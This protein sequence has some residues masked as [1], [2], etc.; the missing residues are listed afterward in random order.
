M[1]R[2]FFL[3]AVVLLFAET[4][5]A[6]AQNTKPRIA[7][8]N[9]NVA[10][11]IP[12][13][14]GAAAKIG[15]TLRLSFFGYNSTEIT[16]VDKL[17]PA[18]FDIIVI[19]KS[20]AQLNDWFRKYANVLKT[21]KL[22]VNEVTS[23]DGNLK[24]KDYPEF[25]DY[26]KNGGSDNAQRLFQFIGK[27]FFDLPFTIRPSVERPKMAFYHPDAPCLFY[28]LASYEKWYG[29]HKPSPTTHRYNPDSLSIGIVFSSFSYIEKNI[30][31]VDS[32]IRAIEHK[33][34]N[35][36][37]LMRSGNGDVDTLLMANGITQVDAVIMVLG[38]FRF[39]DYEKGI[40][41][42][43]KIN[44]PLLSAMNH[45]DYSPEQWEKSIDGLTLSMG[46]T[47]T[48]MFKD[49]VFEPMVISGGVKN[50]DGKRIYVPIMYQLNWRV[51][52]A[53]AWAR[54]HKMNNAGKRM[55][56]TFYSEDGGKANV[57][58]HPAN[59][60]NAPASIIKLL[61][62]MKAR[63]W[64]VGEKPLP[65]AKKL[66]R[67]LSQETSN[68]GNWAQGEI[69]RRVR[70]GNV[71]MIPES[72]YRQWFA[73]LPLDKQQQLVDSWGPPPGNVM[74]HTNAAGQKFIIIPKL[75][76]GNVL[77]A[78]NPD[79]GYLQNSKMLYSNTK[80][81]PSHQYFAFYCWFQKIYQPHVRFSIFNNL[82]VMEHKYIGPSKKDWLGMMTG[83]YPN[84][85]I[86][87]LMSG[88][89][90]KEIM[91]DL[92]VTYFNTIVPSG[93]N[94]NLTELRLKIKQLSDQVVPELKVELEKGIV[95]ETKRLKL[96]EQ[97]HLN[98]DTIQLQALLTQLKNYFYEIDLGNMPSGTHTLGEVPEGETR[99]AMIRAML[100][101]EF[102][103]LVQQAAPQ[104]ASAKNINAVLTD[105]LLKQKNSAQSQQKYLGIA[106]DTLSQQLQLALEY[107]RRIVASKNEI[108]QYLNA[109]EGKYIAPSSTD[110]PIRN[111]NAIPTGRNPYSF[112]AATAPTQEAWVMA[113]RL[114]DTLIAKY[115][116]KNKSYPRKIGFVLW[117]SEI[118]KNHGVLEAEILY[119][120]GAKPVWDSKSNVVG[121]EL[122]PKEVLKRPRIDVVATT[123]GDYRDVFRDKA[124]LI[125]EAV[126]L[127]AAA[128]EDS[129]IVRQHTQQYIA[130]LTK[131]GKSDAE[132]KRLSTIRVFSPAV[133][134]Y[135][136]SL[137]NVTKANDTWQSDTALSNLYISRMGH[138]YGKET[139][140]DYERDYFIS[141][142]QSV[143]AG[144][145]SRSSNMYGLL[146]AT[147]EPVAFFG[148]L[149]M[150][151][152]NSTGGRN[153]EMYMN[154][155]RDAKGS[156]LETLDDFYNKELQSRAF[157]PKWIEAMM[158]DDNSGAQYMQNITENLW[159]F[160]VTSPNIVQDKDW[161]ELNDVFVKDKF[162]LGLDEFFEKANP[163]AKQNILST[164][165]G[166]AEKGYWKADKEVLANLSKALAQSV[167]KNGAGCSSVICN[168]TTVQKFAIANLQAIPGG[169]DLAQGYL[170]GIATQTT[171]VPSLA[172]S[173]EAPLVIPSIVKASL[174]KALTKSFVKTKA[175]SPTVNNAP[176]DNMIKG[177]E[178][179]ETI[180]KKEE[181]QVMQN[182]QPLKK[183]GY[184]WFALLAF[185]AIG[186]V[187]QG[188]TRNEFI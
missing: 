9:A 88:E 95:A 41:Q 60:F 82:E 126:K 70:N 72:Q 116:D 73:E 35:A 37:A 113:Q 106:K 8:V 22:Y 46:S 77:L 2:L 186:W 80:L 26:I 140:G 39:V 123:S 171:A 132:A 57:G 1:K 181:K 165:L 36:F 156:K 117:A 23:Y 159:A 143:D 98:A 111:P 97:L 54:L 33:G 96:D 40:A 44:V 29:S 76:F 13:L 119:L 103:S 146:D 187:I 12:E 128:D 149:Q 102:E 160:N 79:W 59:Y 92:P 17:N 136:T 138:A 129:N 84:I 105:V 38:S 184:V 124:E 175:S 90:G 101:L 83:D 30:V 158:K 141:N 61:D 131:A 174:I 24:A 176:T 25:A 15:D 135:A 154:D 63:G 114:A 86:S 31:P 47:L 170:K 118:L 144:A 188:K 183:P 145:F 3:L 27:R 52:R 157:N 167:A 168:T 107:Q 115:I 112:D 164:M 151:V 11:H 178:V 66:A 4:K 163:Y 137:Q 89:G 148:G 99:V 142:L 87:F 20:D 182:D 74:V 78:P 10:F 62:S 42:L 161:N 67:L 125:E 152:R 155:L 58:S 32:L 7:F 139:M 43:Q 21:K 122:I 130:Q 104:K 53:L 110:D 6:I 16:S 65:T 94:P 50:A 48:P 91:S 150:A 162:R 49:A 28:S 185:M 34:H 120:I 18:D 121:V 177:Y 166:A 93:L 153:M 71:I 172:A 127:V 51:D 55:M 45:Y 133:G 134:T 69:D 108:N 179:K 68:I 169:S 100:G 19:E 173:T 56:V 75:Q 85:H 64:N 14:T 180:I 5:N 81:P 147:P 109:F